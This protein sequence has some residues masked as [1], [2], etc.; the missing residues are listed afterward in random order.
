M[1]VLYITEQGATLRKEGDLLVVSK[2]GQTLQEVWAIKV[3]QVV[4]FGNIHVTTPAIHY[5]LKEGID[6]VFNS[7]YGKYYGRL[8]STESR[9]GQLRQQQ[10]E[11]VARAD[12][13]LAVAREIV[14]GKL[15][16]QRTLL[17]RYLRE[18][19]DPVL[20]AGV[21]G[22]MD[23]VEKLDKAAA[24]ASVMGQEGQAGALYFKAFKTL[25]KQDLGFA[26]R[27]HRPPPD[28]VNSL[29]SFGYSLLT[30]GLNSAVHAV[31]LDPFLG[32]LHSTEYSRPSLALDLVEEFRPVIVD[33]V[34]LRAVNT[35]AITV[36]DF[37]P[38]DA[39]RPGVFLNQDGIKKYLRHYEERVETTVLH[40]VDK[41]Q[42]TYRRAFE[43]QARHLARVIL[44]QE[45]TYM[46]FLVK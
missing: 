39:S 25:L 6:C 26:G 4:L 28:P 31:G 30:N 41:V 12:A 1:A 27:E 20:D 43:L 46:P 42:V 33:S 29:L 9:F 34:V 13:R 10:L 3:E 14:R 7:G 11:I 24:V 23:C 37:A 21:S 36:E 15:L 2:D 5:L 16:N 35:R 18:K 44:G 32:F 38:P 8:F 17:Q 22:I 19:P 40:P 45:T